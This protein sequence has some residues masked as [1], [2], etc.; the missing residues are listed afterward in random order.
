MATEGDLNPE[1][2]KTNESR[3]FSED[4]LR[5]ITLVVRR[6]MEEERHRPNSGAL[7]N[8]SHSGK[9]C[10][11]ENRLGGDAMRMLNL[12]M[13]TE[14]E[15]GTQQEE[16]PTGRNGQPIQHTDSVALVHLT[17]NNKKDSSDPKVSRYLVAKGLPSLPMRVV[18]RIWNLQFVEMEDM[19]PSPRT[20]RLAEQEPSSRSLQDSLV[21]AL[22]H[23]QAIQQHKAHCSVTDITTWV[24]YFSLY[25]AVL[26]KKE[27]A[28]VPS[29]VAHMH[30]VLHLCYHG[31]WSTVLGFGGGDLHHEW[32]VVLCIIH[33]LPP[34]PPPP[35]Q[36]K[37]SSAAGTN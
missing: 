14:T 17:A 6:L 24:K 20:L 3:G 19:L 15:D 13:V 5:A 26:A 23:F 8:D 32:N 21:G 30:T 2:E 33:T 29:M 4:Q 35:P 37:G 9:S 16:L 31:M 1:N 36:K 34:P 27:L 7:A 28:M 18:E 11:V 25:M 22:S 10:L 12:P